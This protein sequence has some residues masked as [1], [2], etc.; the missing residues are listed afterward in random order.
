MSFPRLIIHA[1]PDNWVLAI[2]AAKVASLASASWPPD[3][4]QAFHYENGVVMAVKRNKASVTVF[5][6]RLSNDL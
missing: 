6:S 5:Q 4:I 2:R 1:E 3:G